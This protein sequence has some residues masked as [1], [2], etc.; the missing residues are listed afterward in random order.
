LPFTV[1][2]DVAH[3]PP[4]D[5]DATRATYDSWHGYWLLARDGHA[6]AYPFGFGLSYTELAIA[7]ARVEQVGEALVVDSVATNLGGRPGVEVVQVYAGWGDRPDRLVGFARVE[8][9]AGEERSIAVSVPR[10]VLAHRTPDGGWEL[11]AGPVR[12]MVGRHATDPDA[13][14]FEVA[15]SG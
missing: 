2:A 10:A 5:A 6:P 3:L 8:L 14:R 11:P 13:H 9:A 1:P 15:F 12:V 7:A 4:F